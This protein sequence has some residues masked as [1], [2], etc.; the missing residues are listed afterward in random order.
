MQTSAFEVYVLG[1][2]AVLE[3]LPV[4]IAIAFDPQCERVQGNRAF[5][6]LAG[7]ST[8]ENAS[9]GGHER[10][11]QRYHFMNGAGR[12]T[13]EQLPMR[14]A[15]TA[16]EDVLDVPVQM[17][18]HDGTQFAL[19]ASAWPLRDPSGVIEG[20]IA[21]FVDVT[22]NTQAEQRAEQ[23]MRALRESERRY[24]LITEAMPEFVWLDAPDGSAI[25]SNRRWLEYTGLTEEQNEGLGWQ[26]VVHPDDQARLETQRARTLETGEPYEGECRYRGKDGKYRWFLFR[27]IPV[28]EEGG[29]I[30]SWLGTATDIDKQKR[31]EAQQA[32]FALAS[33][34][35]GSTLDVGTTLERIA[36]LA[37]DTL[38][39]WCQIDLPAAD[40]A[41]R[42]A[43]VAH[44]DPGKKKD[45]SQLVGARI[46]DNAAPFGPPAVLRTG[47]PQ[48]LSHISE[49]A[50]RKTIPS[51]DHRDVYA[52]I[53]YEGG[54][55]VPLRC[56]ERV[57]GVLGIASD[58]TT[59]LYTD[60]DVATALELGRRGASALENAQ[61]YAR[62]HRV[63]TTLQRALLPVS[64]PSNAQ[65]RFDSAYASETVDEGEAVGGDWYDAFALDEDRIAVS[66]GDVAG[67]GVD[68]AVTM[69]TVRQAIRAAAIG[70]H[71]VCEVLAR[72]NAMIALERR[73]T[74]VTALFGVFDCRTKAFTYALAGHP[75]PLMACDNGE[76]RVLPGSGPPLGDAFDPALCH[77]HSI[78]VQGNAAIV[79]YTDGLIEYSRDLI[80]ASK[81]LEKI[82]SERYFLS[83]ERPAQAIIDFMLD[84]PQRD[85]I[86]VLVMTIGDLQQAEM[87]VSMPARGRSAPVLR[88]R[89][90]AFAKAQGV[91]DEQMFR[92]L[93]AAG[94]AI[95]NAIEHAYDGEEG[96]VSLRAQRDGEGFCIEV[97]DRG[98]WREPRPSGNGLRGRGRAIM[99]SL[100][101]EMDVES[102]AGGTTVRL[103]F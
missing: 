16:A 68:A 24:R 78:T 32:F 31:A 69:S 30:T 15:A 75:R 40:G 80:G 44:A 25:Y 82:V 55:L 101:R 41:L 10:R 66:M 99:Q 7:L 60:F 98:A 21:V 73:A 4:P 65:L 14:R 22:Q 89:L 70:G 87:H 97:S 5:R 34:L 20:S 85:D 67:H 1:L 91:P 2:L 13:A 52:R 64:L 95:A 56:G 102:Q 79:F 53:G 47:K 37:I 36:R 46:Y 29:E 38:G 86:A 83:E 90:R 77:E 50:V 11:I 100:V 42:V 71:T 58:D 63:A 92:M 51:Q 8:T 57:L 84:A 6:R 9:P 39:T 17:V 94:E 62:E 33:D 27:S 96:P 45:L 54:L 76:F 103:Q 3:R 35:L 28:R 12:L 93:N 72:A 48:L 88:A 74:M 19:I 59:R 26:R 81:R 23:A 43:V 18:R 61:S 49:D